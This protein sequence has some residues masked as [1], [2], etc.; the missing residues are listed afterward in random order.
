MLN[1]KSVELITYFMENKCIGNSKIINS[2]QTLKL[3]KYLLFQ[4]LKA[5]KYVR[6]HRLNIQFSEHPI[7]HM[8]DIPKS[9][10]FVKGATP[11]KIEDY[12]HSHSIYYLKYQFNVFH[13]NICIYFIISH[14]PT[15]IEKKKY[16]EYVERMYMWLYISNIHSSNICSS[17]LN[18]FLYFTQLEKLMPIPHHNEKNHIILDETNVNTAYTYSC[19]KNNDIVI[20]RKEEWFKVFIH[21]TFHAFGLDFSSVDN[22]VAVKKILQLFNANSLVNLFEAYTEFWARIMNILFISYFVVLGTENKSTLPFTSFNKTQTDKFISH[23]NTFIYLE[24]LYS[25]F[26]M[27]K[28]L[29]YMS[30]QYKDLVQFQ[31]ESVIKLKYKEKSNVLSYYIITNILMFFYQDFFI[32]CDRNNKTIFQSGKTAKY[33]IAFCNFIESQYKRE[34]FLYFIQCIQQ[35][36]LS[37]KKSNLIIRNNL[38]MTI[39]ELG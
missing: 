5:D 17:T 13:R 22:T 14:H 9:R 30:I 35:S 23:F 11:K 21:E 6:Q 27:I 12:I 16:D 7:T 26:Q 2:P 4:I 20:F 39:C 36:M 18:I 10:I 25:C 29:D 3:L 8:S 24:Q 19:Q 31:K 37:L 32:W 28:V 33:Q 15:S 38:R 1:K 34:P